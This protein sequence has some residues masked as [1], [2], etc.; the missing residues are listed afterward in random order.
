MGERELGMRVDR[1]KGPLLVV[2]FVLLGSSARPAHAQGTLEDAHNLKCVFPLFATGNWTK[3]DATAEVKPAELTLMFDS[4]NTEEGTARVAVVES[5]RAPRNYGFAPA[6]II[7]RQSL[8]SLH[9][10]QVGDAGPLYVTTVFDSPSRPGKLK[11]VHTRHEYIGMQMPGY[12]SRPE[13][14]YGECEVLP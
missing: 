13:Q 5:P 1:R 12:T 8:A 2:M 10:M 7:A 4:I 11:A 14:Y 9:L 3:G 6:H